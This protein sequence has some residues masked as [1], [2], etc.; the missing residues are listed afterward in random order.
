MRR[1]RAFCWMFVLGLSSASFAAPA[2][3]SV[4]AEPRFAIRQ[5]QVEGNSLL[6]AG[7]IDSLLKD[8]TGA[9]RSFAD[10]EAARRALEARYLDAGY[11]TVRVV[12]PE[13]EISAGTV[14]L[15]V[16]EMKLGSVEL[17]AARYHDIDNVRATVPAL[18]E[19]SVP[20]T[21]A[22]AE[23]LRLANENPSK[24]TH[25]LLKPDPDGRRV[26]ALLRLEDEKP[27]KVFTIVDNTGT[28]QTG[29]TR[30]GIGY[31]HANLFN[32][33]HVAT[34]QYITSGEKPSDV[35]VYGFGYRLPLYDLADVVDLYGG[36][37]DVNSGTVAG[38]FNVSGK[39]DIFGVRYTHNF[40]KTSA[41]EHKLVAGL[42]YR[43][44]QNSVMFG[45][46]QL[47]ADVTVRPVD[48]TWSGLWRG[49]SAR[50]GGYAAVLDNLPGGAKGGDADF[51]AARAGAVARYRIY[52][53]G[54]DASQQ[55]S[56][57]WQ[58]RLAVDAQQTG[59]PLVPG[60]Q[61]GIGGQDSVRGFDER[62][63]S[64]DRGWRGGLE[65]Y[66]PDIGGMTGVVDARLRLCAFYDV[67]RTHRIDARPGEVVDEA[68]ASVGV[69]M[70]FGIGK[71]LSVRLDYGYVLDGAGTVSRG[72]SKL[73]GSIAYVF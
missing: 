69:G 18:V 71:S 50:I 6:P 37:S 19:G 5:I 51:A 56:G 68:I 36:H 22:V 26:D 29:N 52:R 57:D 7:A 33:D 41:F 21:V 35:K 54:A 34:V 42:D 2:A 13:Q 16:Q 24:Q 53:F 45:G 1:A 12:L 61:F 11:S 65:I 20:D 9:D 48:L 44:Y 14:R 62:A 66:T 17:L 15:V 47:G 49:E 43:A 10:I 58:L 25:V 72:D 30:I 70:R 31:Q 46:S 64:G 73:H 23:S 55:L 40:T 3:D 38:L 39:G 67:G 4:P 8:F 28:R 32:R 60:E 27:W 59:K 63:V